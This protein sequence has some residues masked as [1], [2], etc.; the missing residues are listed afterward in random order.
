MKLLQW[1]LLTFAWCPLSS[2]WICCHSSNNSLSLILYPCEQ[3]KM[4]LPFSWNW[5]QLAD[6]THGKLICVFELSF[7]TPRQPYIL[8]G[9]VWWWPLPYVLS[10]KLNNVYNHWFLRNGSNLP[11]NSQV[12]CRIKKRFTMKLIIYMDVK[13]KERNICA[14]LKLKPIC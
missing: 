1:E 10:Q 2:N 13:S 8:S 3:P 4:T 12:S 11:Y 14:K 7:R 6:R 5:I 9:G